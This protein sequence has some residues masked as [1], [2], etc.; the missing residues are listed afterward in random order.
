MVN[1]LTLL[2]NDRCTVQITTSVTKS[3]G[4]TGKSWVTLAADEPCKLSFIKTIGQNS[5]ASPVVGAAEVIQQTKLFLRPDLN[6]PAGS[7]IIVYH[8]NRVLHFEASSI[9]SVFTNHQEIILK[10]VQKW[11]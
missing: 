9:E 4:A 2:W 7:R 3:N 11:A 1:P 10:D 6:I 8:Q 5:A